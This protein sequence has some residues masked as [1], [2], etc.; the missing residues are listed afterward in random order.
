MESGLPSRTPSGLFPSGPQ[1]PTYR[2]PHL[3]RTS[4]VVTGAAVTAA[5]LL[6]WGLLAATARGYIWFTIASG[7]AAWLAALGLSKHGDRGVAVGVALA[8]GAGL[9]IAFGLVAVRWVTTGWPLW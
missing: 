8:T 3:V 4:A 9:A 7:A 1:R 5:W 2:E 6:L